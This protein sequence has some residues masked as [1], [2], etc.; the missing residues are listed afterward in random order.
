M[1][2]LKVK[3][4]WRQSSLSLEGTAVFCLRPSTESMRPTYTTERNL[5][6]SESADLNLNPK[7]PLQKH[8]E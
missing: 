8:L 5:L 7:T 3:A 1:W 2:Q 6:Y 4:I